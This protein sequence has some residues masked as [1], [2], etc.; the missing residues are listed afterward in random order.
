MRTTSLLAIALVMV[1]CDDDDDD[2]TLTPDAPTT[3]AVSIVE[4]AQATPSLSTLV[5]ALQFASDNN[6]LVNLLSGPGP[7]TVFAPTNAAFDALA[8]ELTG[9]ANAT[10]SALLTAANRPLLRTV[11]QYHVLSSEVTAARI[12][13][14]EAITTAEGSI[15]KIEDGTPPT[16]QDERNR[17][18]NITTT[19]VEASNGVVHVI[20]RVLLPSD[21]NIAQVAQALAAQTPGQF[22]VVLEAVNAS[23]LAPT[24]AGTQP[25][26]VFVPTD[27]AF[28]ALL[29]ELGV[30][31]DQLLANRA[32]LTQV[33]SYHVVPGRVLEVDL[34]VGSRVAT[35]E[36]GAF[37]VNAPLTITD[38]RGRIANITSTDTF[39]NNGVIHVID[40]VLL[41][42]P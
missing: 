7:L 42:A 38:E 11:L 29:T 15:F 23:G 13:F 41:P 36:T 21:Q 19:D 27:A 10:G 25:F 30:T 37:T 6:D 33:L 18:A 40:R 3:A 28:A 9:N 4:T 1:G 2:G 24:L 12:P 17:L 5:A 39:A 31:R 35:V 14:G 8:V 20:D 22:S 32:L 16:I 34:P 26:T